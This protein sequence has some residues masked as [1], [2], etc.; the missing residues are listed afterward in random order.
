VSGGWLR[1]ARIGPVGQA[2]RRRNGADA[3]LATASSLARRCVYRRAPRC[4]STSRTTATWRTR[5]TGTGCAW[6]TAS[7][8]PTRPRYPTRSGGRYTARVTFPDPGVYW[9]HPHIRE[10][11]NQELGLH[12]NVIVVPPDTDYWAPV[13]RELALTLDDILIEDGRI[14]PFSPD[15]TTH[16]AMGRFG[17]CSWSPASPT[18]R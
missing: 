18:W 9:Y 5:R 14:A 13:N 15:E 8:A 3:R 6:R 7:T 10:D 12:G 16:A 2:D 11:Y 17:K 1:R 4:W